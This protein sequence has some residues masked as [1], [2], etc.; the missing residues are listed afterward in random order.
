MLTA[1]LLFAGLIV[2]YVWMIYGIHPSDEGTGGLSCEYDKNYRVTKAEMIVIKDGK[3]V[4]TPAD[5]V[6]CKYNP[7]DFP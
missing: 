1:V 3:R 7:N 2:F 6:L 5:P 4:I